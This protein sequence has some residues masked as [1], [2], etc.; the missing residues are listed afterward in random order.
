MTEK[1]ILEEF[2]NV[3][4]K[5]KNLTQKQRDVLIVSIRLFAK[6]GYA[7]TST[8]QIAEAAHQSEGT[9][10]KHFKSKANI[11]REAL[12]PIVREVVPDL[13]DELASEAIREQTDNIHD[14]FVFFVHNRMKFASENQDAL[15]VF[16]SEILY[17]ADIREQYL[18]YAPERFLNSFRTIVKTAQ[19][20]GQLVDWP[21]RIIFR[22]LLSILG[23][24]FFDR[25]VLFPD[26]EWDD[27]T[28][29]VY[30]VR[31]LDR[32]LALKPTE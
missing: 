22:Y 4:N 19:D 30:M 24:Y 28:E 25:Y 15:K 23:S 9:M 26:R 12:D 1:N 27:A 16:L 3:V 21:F 18:K 17:N 29:E 11:L 10:F 14:F 31:E 6:Q 2:P 5:D 7:N 20:R 8:R 13:L 32:T